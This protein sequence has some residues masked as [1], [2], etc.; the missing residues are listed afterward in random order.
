MYLSIEFVVHA[1]CTKTEYVSNVGPKIVV[2]SCT[3]TVYIR[4][5]RVYS[6]ILDRFKLLV[7]TVIVV[8]KMTCAP[9]PVLISESKVLFQ[10]TN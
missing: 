3:E 7:S 1:K 2:E 6:L 4:T 8:S 5:E 10:Y 9:N